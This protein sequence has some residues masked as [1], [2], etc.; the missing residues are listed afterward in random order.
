VLMADPRHSSFPASVKRQSTRSISPS[1]PQSTCRMVH[2]AA[3]SRLLGAVL[4]TE[5]A[6][7]KALLGL[8]DASAT[9]LS[10][11]SAYASASTTPVSRAVLAV[12]GNLRSADAALGRYAGAVDGWRAGLARLKEVEED[13]SSIVRDREILVTRLLKASKSDAGKPARVTSPHASAASIS[14][15][16]PKVA[17]AQAELQACEQTLARRE[18]ELD[19]LRIESI[20]DGL[21]A[22]CKALVECAWA[23]GEMGKE[24]LRALEEVTPSKEHSQSYSLTI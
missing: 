3:D 10:A 13:V 23:W 24:G 8:L 12:A 16:G 15:I 19:A 11:L 18:A 7:H 17:A 20:K 5:A 21:D 2:R 14:T 6:Y 9:T 22:R 4:T 1:A